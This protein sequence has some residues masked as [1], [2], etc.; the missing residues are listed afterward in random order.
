MRVRSNY[1]LEHS[2]K[3]ALTE[4]GSSTANNEGWKVACEGARVR[5]CG[6]AGALED[7]EEADI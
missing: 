5:A 4:I 7:G 3:G 1:R 2:V 6:V